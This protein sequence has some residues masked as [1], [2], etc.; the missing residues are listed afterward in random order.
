MYGKS[1]FCCFSCE[2]IIRSTG[3]IPAT[4]CL[5]SGRLHV[6]LKASQ[7]E[8]LADP[9]NAGRIKVSRRDLAPAIAARRDGG[10]TIASTM[11]ISHLAGIKVFS[12]GGL[13]GVHRGGE[14]SLDVSADLTELGRTPI[15][16]VSA[17]VKSILD[18]GRT[19]EYLETEGVTVGNFG[20]S[21]DFPAFF[22][23]KSGFQC[24]WNFESTTQVAEMLY[25]Q[26][27]L[28]L[29]SG[30]LIACPIPDEYEEAGLK[31]Q[32]SVEQAIRESEEYGVSKTGKDATP[33]LLRRVADLT[34]GAS[35][36]NNIA[37][38]ENTSRIGGEIAVEYAKLVAE[39]IQYAPTKPPVS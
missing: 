15:A 20:P 27:R 26:Y 13:G 24:P 9:S 3:A 7:I 4:I 19:L 37:L 33:W 12:T 30:A 25:A 6:G 5:L 34:G 17:G 39:G 21:K 11:I 2:R 14:L 23:R 29:S 22:S 32:Q 36:P 31:I 1:F 10:T 35:I 38:V 8:R 18:V 28:Q 16:V